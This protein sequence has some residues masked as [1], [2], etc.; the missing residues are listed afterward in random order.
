MRSLE[1]GRLRTLLHALLL[2]VFLVVNAQVAYAADGGG[3]MM[4]PLN[5][6]SSEGVP[7]DGYE[8]SAEGGSVS[9][10]KTNAYTFIMNGLFTLLRLV[11]GLSWWAIEFALRFPLIKMMS[12]PAQKVSDTYNELVV[13]T[14]GLK[15]LLLSWAFVFGGTSWFGARPARGSERSS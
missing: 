1:R 13:D 9:S 8:L 5:V 15:G 11:V 6:D 7:L 2:A 12:D 4:A 3:D 14:L 10:L